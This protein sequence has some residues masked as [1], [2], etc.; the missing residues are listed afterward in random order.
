MQ[1]NFINRRAQL[2]LLCFVS[3]LF[4]IHA[5]AQ[6]IAD[7]LK[8]TESEQYEAATDVYKKLI[9]AEPNKA[10]YYYY[11]GENYLL[12]DNSDSALAIF[13]AG[14]QIDKNNPLLMIGIAKYDLDK[15]NVAEM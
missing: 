8:L 11:F 5:Q 1:N 4:S 3:L 2:I 15:Y 13:K 9:A 7:A 12:A 14:Q 6:T 10:D